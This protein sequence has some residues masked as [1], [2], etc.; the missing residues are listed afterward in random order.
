MILLA[1]Q[2][3]KKRHDFLKHYYQEKIIGF[4]GRSTDVYTNVAIKIYD[5]NSTEHA[6]Y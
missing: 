2:K 3:L 5:I 4:E 6:N 1:L